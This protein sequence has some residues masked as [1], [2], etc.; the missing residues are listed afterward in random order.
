MEL[1]NAVK[2]AHE[3]LKSETCPVYAKYR[4]EHPDFDEEKDRVPDH[5]YGK[6]V[7]LDY[8]HALGVGCG[9]CGAYWIPTWVPEELVAAAPNTQLSLAHPYIGKDGKLYQRTLDPEG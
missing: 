9:S 5:W 4:E 2:N 1:R 8:S 3:A 6:P 7:V